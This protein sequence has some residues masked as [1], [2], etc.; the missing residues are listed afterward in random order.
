MGFPFSNNENEKGQL[1]WLGVISETFLITGLEP[2]PGPSD[3]QD[4]DGGAAGRP[5]AALLVEFPAVGP[6]PARAARLHRAVQRNRLP[7]SLYLRVIPLTQ[8]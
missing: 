1:S 2:D 4:G 6:R 8:V 3:L 7:V 5:D